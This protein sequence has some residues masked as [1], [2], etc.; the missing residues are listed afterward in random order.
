M[1]LNVNTSNAIPGLNPIDSKVL[2]TACDAVLKSGSTHLTTSQVFPDGSIPRQD[3][4]DALEILD[5]QGYVELSKTIGGK[6]NFFFVRTPG[7]EAFAQACLDGYDAAVKAV[8]EALVTKGLQDNAAIAADTGVD[9][10]VVNHILEVMASYGHIGVSKAIGG[11]IIVH[12]V[13]AGLRRSL[14]GG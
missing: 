2:A 4:D 8:A 13:K 1:A 14:Q 5:D 9:A 11:T 7:F 10:V 12:T 3:L 6:T